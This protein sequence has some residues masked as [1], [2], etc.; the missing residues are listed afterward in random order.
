MSTIYGCHNRKPLKDQALVQD[1]W[2][3]IGYHQEARRTVT[4]PDLM[5]KDCRYT[6]TDLGRVDAKC[7]GCKHRAQEAA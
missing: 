6:H 1:G 3:R 7:S 2:W 4:V 5:T